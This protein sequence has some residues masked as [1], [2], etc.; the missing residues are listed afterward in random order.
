MVGNP[1]RQGLWFGNMRVIA[2][3]KLHGYSASPYNDL[4]NPAYVACIFVRAKPDKV[5]F[6]Y[7]IASLSGVLIQKNHMELRQLNADVIAGI[8]ETLKEMYTNLKALGIGLWGNVHKGVITGCDIPELLH[9]PLES[10]LKEKLNIEVFIENELN[11]TAYGYYQELDYQLPATIALVALYRGKPPRAG[12]IIDGSLHKGDRNLAGEIACLPCLSEKELTVQP[13]YRAAVID[14]ASKIVMTL[15]SVLN[16][17][18]VIFISDQLDAAD[19]K[20]TA[21]HCSGHMPAVQ[22][23]ELVKLQH[24]DP[25]YMGG[26]VKRTIQRI[27]CS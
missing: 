2:T 19:L 11:L 22:I 14:Q 17:K 7:G 16:P 13:Q 3:Q 4:E 24:P 1:V 18:T 23:P 27:T 26:L 9:V 20:R 6:T 10:I 5:S 8:V 25:S 12:I 21:A 15:A